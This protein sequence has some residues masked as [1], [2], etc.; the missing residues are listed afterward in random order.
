MINKSLVIIKGLP[1]IDILY[2]KM[3]NIPIIQYNLKNKR[4]Y[5][6]R[7][8]SEDKTPLDNYFIAERERLKLIQTLSDIFIVEKEDQL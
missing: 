4:K 6:F 2:I 8:V 1:G 7:W 5:P 3:N